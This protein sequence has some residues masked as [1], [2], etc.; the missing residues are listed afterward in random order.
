[1]NN[2]LNIV[3]YYKKG[4]F[5]HSYEIKSVTAREILDSRGNPTVRATVTLDDGTCASADVPSGAS[6]G[7]FE[8]YELRD[9][10]SKRYG[11]KGVLRAVENV[12]T[13]ISRAL[14]GCPITDQGRIDEIMIELD[15]TE[16]KKN[17]GANAILAVSLAAA[18]AGAKANGVELFEYIGYKENAAL[19]CPMFNILNGGAHAKN[20]IEMQEFMVV[21]TGFDFPDT[22]RVGSEIYHALGA[23]LNKSG[24]STGVGDE[25]GF[26]PIL[27]S[28][29][30]AL[31]FIC[32]AICAA[33]YS[34]ESVKI[35]LDA[36]ASEWHKG[37]RYLMPKSGKETSSDELIGYYERLIAEY[38]IIS[39][40]DGLAEE[41]IEGWRALT[42]SL[43][44]NV[45]LVGDDLFVTNKKRLKMGI[46][47]KIG[48]SI[49]IKLNQIGTLTETL[50][51][52]RLAREHGYKHVVS[53]RS[54]ETEDSFIADLA[55]ATNAP[56]IKSGAPA[57]GERTAKYNRLIEIFEKI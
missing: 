3:K 24:Y 35:A 14:I 47:E 25:G 44:K 15:G 41:D 30:E 6:T 39:I 27:R 34:D 23:L 16:N 57:R 55:V 37:D 50:E 22:L 1:M 29:E 52:I 21:P 38:P 28:D 12:N 51:V 20:N 11:G 42:A 8:A 53:H 45:M 31:D 48:N 19:P 4:V 2:L 36:A 43:T 33:G 10:D 49:L 32:E 54:G 7:I 26:A 46:D 9:G 56:Y 17:L 13:K 18:R 40:E 5:M